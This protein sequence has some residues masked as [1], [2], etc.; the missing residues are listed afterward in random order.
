MYFFKKNNSNISGDPDR[1]PVRLRLRLRGALPGRLLHPWAGG[2]G[3]R[4]QDGLQ[5]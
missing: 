5:R 2:H 1:S 3:R 4:L